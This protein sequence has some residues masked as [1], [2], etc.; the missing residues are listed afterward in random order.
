MMHTRLFSRNES[1]HRIDAQHLHRRDLLADG[2]RA[3]VGAHRRRAGPGDDQHRDHRTH[4]GHRAERGARAAEIRGAEF[5]QQ[6]VERETH[7]HRE[8]DRHEQRR[9]QRD[10]HDEPR[11]LEEFP[12]LERSSEQEPHRVRRHGEQPSD[13]LHRTRR[14]PSDRAAHLVSR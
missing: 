6:D 14:S 11:L 10:P 2:A 7:Q 9:H 3:E 12:G 8:R 1:L 4:L 5:A 13:G